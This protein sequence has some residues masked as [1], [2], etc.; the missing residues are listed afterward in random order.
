MLH[1]SC[2]TKLQIPSKGL[3]GST[4]SKEKQVRKDINGKKKL[5]CLGIFGSFPCATIFIFYLSYKFK[6]YQFPFFLQKKYPLNILQ[7]ILTFYRKFCK[8]GTLSIDFTMSR[9]ESFW[10]EGGTGHICGTSLY[11][12]APK[13]LRP[14]GR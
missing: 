6:H 10:D 7:T 12:S 13:E 3:K 9:K 14:S 5:P 1:L 4:I 2:R 8:M 11:N